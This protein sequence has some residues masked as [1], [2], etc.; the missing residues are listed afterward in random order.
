MGEDCSMV[1]GCE[2]TV[3]YIALKTKDGK[4]TYKTTKELVRV[5]D[6]ITL[7][8]YLHL[9]TSPKI[10]E[11]NGLRGGSKVKILEFYRGEREL[12]VVRVIGVP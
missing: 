7:D 11:G 10:D 12:A 3:G 2:D 6:T 4:P 5:G 8:A 1:G 9:R